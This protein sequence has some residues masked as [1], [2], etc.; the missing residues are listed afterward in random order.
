MA[1]T[2]FGG[3]E[4]LIVFPETGKTSAIMVSE[5]IRKSIEEH[6]FI[7]PNK[8]L[9]PSVTVS[10]GVASFSSDAKTGSEVIKK[11]DDMLYK[12]KSEGKNIVKGE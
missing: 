5:R 10:I 12:A 9:S 1:I 8:N 11:A 3:E 2:R 7:L 4:F 6:T